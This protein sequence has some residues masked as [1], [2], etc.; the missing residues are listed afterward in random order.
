M[1]VVYT[2]VVYTREAW[3]LLY[4]VESERYQV[5]RFEGLAVLTCSSSGGTSRIKTV[6]KSGESSKLADW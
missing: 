6:H 3:R 5:I 2:C 4:E 1:R